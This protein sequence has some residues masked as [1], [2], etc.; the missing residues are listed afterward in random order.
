[1]QERER[2]WPVYNQS[3]LYDVP[4]FPHS[5]VVRKKYDQVCHLPLT[6]VCFMRPLISGPQGDCLKRI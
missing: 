2:S 5:V 6:A 3:G 4:V 1:V